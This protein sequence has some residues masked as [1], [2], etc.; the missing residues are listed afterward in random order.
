MAAT[1]IY[2]AS[3]NASNTIIVNGVTMTMREYNKMKKERMNAKKN[4][5]KK[6]AEVCEIKLLPEDVK[7]LLKGVKVFKSLVSFYIHGKKTFGRVY[8]ELMRL[9]DM[10]TKFG[11]F[12]NTADEINEIINE[13]ETIAK[14]RE[15]AAYAYVEKLSYKMNDAH[16]R[17]QA[18]YDAVMGSNVLN[19]PYINHEIISG[20]G[21]RLGLR[22][23]M[24]RTL[25]AS[26]EIDGIIAKLKQM[27]EIPSD[28]Y[29][30]SRVMSFGC[31]K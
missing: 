10:A 19:S 15:K 8:T 2:S 24:K 12:K 22:I 20:E 7:A 26:W 23:L 18:L 21:R 25:E 3:L 29:D 16:E 27:S 11:C 30:N 13:I 28:I 4:A 31:H 6:K 17:L 5:K 1:S 9:N 14:K